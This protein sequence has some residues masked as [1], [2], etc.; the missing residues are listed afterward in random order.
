[1]LMVALVHYPTINKEGRVVTTS[2]TNFD[3][4]DIARASTTFGV[5]RY[6][7]VTPVELQQQFVRRIVHHW[8]EGS[9]AEYNPTRKEALTAVEIAPDLAAVGEAIE[10]DFGR[11]ATWVATSARRYG[12]TISCATLRRRLRDEPDQ[13]VCLIFGTGSGLHPQILEEADLILE[14]IQ[15]PTAYNHLSVRSA[16]SI[17]LDR[18]LAVRGD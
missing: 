8:L 18:L 5:A 15:G 11:A 16:V 12:N 13:P 4:H 14:P 2:V 10:R 3:I 17:Y 6:Y 1:M 7:L 9:G